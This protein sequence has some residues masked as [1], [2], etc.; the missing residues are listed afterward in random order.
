MDDITPIM[1]THIEDTVAA[2]T[3]MHAQHRRE[4]SAYQRIIDKLTAFLG[5]PAFVGVITIA[6]ALW[7][8]LNVALPRFHFRA[9]D[10]A[11]FYLMQGAIATTALYM[12]VLILTT[13][14][15]ENVLSEHRAQL[16]LQ[17][18]MVNEQKIAKLI[19][20]M[21]CMR[22]DN[23]FVENHFDPEALAM[24]Q[25]ADPRTMLHAMKETTVGLPTN[26]VQ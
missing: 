6:I 15:R 8:A 26:T 12:T 20:M 21:E 9:I 7:V 23:P 2:I 25:P 3:E 5:R 19:Q 4:A 11:P 17:L 14:R 24:A 10:S 1:P 18:A 13:Q 22:R 16:T